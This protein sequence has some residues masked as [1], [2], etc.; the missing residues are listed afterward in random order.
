MGDVTKHLT[1]SGDALKGI[2]GKSKFSKTLLKIQMSTENSTNS[3]QRD[4]S[5]T[6]ND[7]LEKDAAELLEKKW[8]KFLKDLDFLDADISP[9]QKTE[10][11]PM[12][13]KI[14]ASPDDD[15]KESDVETLL[16]KIEELGMNILTIQKKNRLLRARENFLKP[17]KVK[18]GDNDKCP[19]VSGKKYKKCCKK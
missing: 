4:G 7:T 3:D 16:V 9:E 11:F 12:V 19:C 14:Y 8:L 18:I 2:K 13:D 10:L 5:E 6:S 1:L 17:K 15:P